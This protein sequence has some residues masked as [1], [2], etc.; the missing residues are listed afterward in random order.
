M[1]RDLFTDLPAG[2]ATVRV[3]LPRILTAASRIENCTY[4]KIIT[5]QPLSRTCPLVPNSWPKGHV[6][7]LHKR[8]SK[9]CCVRFVLCWRRETS[10]E[11]LYDL[12][13]GNNLDIWPQWDHCCS[14]HYT[15]AVSAIVLL[16]HWGTVTYMYSYKLGHY[17]C[18]QYRYI[19]DC[20]SNRCLQQCCIIFNWIL[21]NKLNEL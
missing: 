10:T 16:A 17:S 20:L 15:T 1:S 14:Y 9:W 7:W 4:R 3:F 2:E 6:S 5:Y 11:W 18:R 12:F 13:P 21:E 19:G 8:A